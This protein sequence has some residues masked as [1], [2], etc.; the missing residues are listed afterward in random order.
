MTSGVQMSPSF[1][2]VSGLFWARS[3]HGLLSLLLIPTLFVLLS[4]SKGFNVFHTLRTKD[5]SEYVWSK[6]GSWPGPG[7]L[8][9]NDIVRLCIMRISSY[10]WNLCEGIDKTKITKNDTQLVRLT[11]NHYR[12]PQYPDAAWLG[13]AGWWCLVAATICLSD[14]VKSSLNKLKLAAVNRRH[15]SCENIFIANLNMFSSFACA[16]VDFFAS[17]KSE[18]IIKYNWILNII[19][20]VCLWFVCLSR[21]TKYTVSIKTCKCQLISDNVDVWSGN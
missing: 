9:R 8:Y 11:D 4:I 16:D 3:Q 7:H 5:G 10:M 14:Q 19:M 20:I 2:S 18:T 21:V 13:W 15:Q 1:L 12:Y 6:R 17:H